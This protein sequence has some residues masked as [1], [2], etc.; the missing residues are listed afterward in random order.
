MEQY[1]K[2]NGLVIDAKDFFNFYTANEKG[3]RWYDS[4]DKL[5][6]S[7][8]QKARTWDMQER[9]KQKGKPPAS[10]PVIPTQADI[11]ASERKKAADKEKRL[12]AYREK[13]RKERSNTP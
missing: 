3:G 9:K 11:E 13:L 12:A 7:W 10:G 8:K 6:K 5:V 2:E 1:V 4:N